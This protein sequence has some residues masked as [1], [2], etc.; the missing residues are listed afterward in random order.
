MDGKR[1]V[2]IRVDEWH[3]HLVSIEVIREEQEEEGG[4]VSYSVEVHY[5]LN[6]LKED[7]T[8]RIIWD[9][10]TVAAEFAEELNP[11]V[12]DPDTSFIKLSFNSLKPRTAVLDAVNHRSGL[13]A[14]E[15]EFAT[16]TYSADWIQFAKR[17]AFDFM[18]VD[19][20][21]LIDDAHV[22]CR[23]TTSAADSF[24][25]KKSYLRDLDSRTINVACGK[26]HFSMYGKFGFKPS[27]ESDQDHAYD[28]L[29]RVICPDGCQQATQLF[30]HFAKQINLEQEGNV[31]A[32]TKACDEEFKHV[33]SIRAELNKDYSLNVLY[34]SCNRIR[35]PSPF[36]QEFRADEPR[37][38][39]S[40]RSAFWSIHGQCQ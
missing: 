5:R 7:A 33:E 14:R 19:K 1:P 8:G 4:G 18:S 2:N 13:T 17:F 28:E 36:Y 38:P 20:L 26:D 32:G 24:T 12:G 25:G 37:L 29:K 34:W 39:T 35:S 40:K 27:D 6:M 21:E 22:Q 23:A 3:P 30:A 15:V 11:P 16:A 10:T 31:F 9:G